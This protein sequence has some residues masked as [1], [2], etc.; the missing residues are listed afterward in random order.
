M[1]IWL[2]GALKYNRSPSEG[3]RRFAKYSKI[4]FIVYVLCAVIVI[5]GMLG[6]Y[7]LAF[8]AIKGAGSRLH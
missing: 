8:M 1:W 7:G 6:F 4:A 2:V 5:V 3:A